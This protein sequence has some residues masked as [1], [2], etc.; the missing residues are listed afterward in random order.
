MSIFGA[1]SVIANGL[2]FGNADGY[3]IGFDVNDSGKNAYRWGEL[4]QCLLAAIHEFAYGFHEGTHTSNTDTTKKLIDAARSIY[5]IPHFDQVRQLYGSGSHLSDEV[6][7]KFLRRGEFG[8]LILH[9][10]LREYYNTIPLLSKIYFKDSLGHTVHGFDCVHVD[11]ATHTLWL[12]ESKLYLDPKKALK[13]LIKDVK[14]H[15]CTDYMN[16]EFSLISKKIK[17]FPSIPEYTEWQKLLASTTKLKDKFQQIRIPLLCTYTCE[18]FTQHDDETTVQFIADYEAKI[19]A[20]KDYF[21]NSFDHPLAD[22]L[23]ITVL[24]F[25]VACKTE[26]VKRLHQKLSLLQALGE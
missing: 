13:E 14:S 22:K 7:E 26:L 12:G 5:K 20:L 9:L 16:A 21:D 4:I 8:E 10:L 1:T 18:L 19:R 2:T 17:H 15:F 11:P 24:L 3:L 25:P 23:N 6:D